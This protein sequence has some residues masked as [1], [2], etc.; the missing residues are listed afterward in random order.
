MAPSLKSRLARPATLAA[1]FL[2]CVSVYTVF[3]S[4]APRQLLNETPTDYVWKYRRVARN[5]LA[6]HGH[7]WKA[8]RGLYTAVPP[9]Y[10]LWV[11]AVYAVAGDDVIREPR[12]IHVSNAITLALCSV[13]VFLIAEQMLG[14]RL[15]GAWAAALWM[16]YPLQLWMVP[17]PLSEVPFTLF[18]YVGVW[19]AL[20]ALPDGRNGWSFGAGLA[21]GVAALMRPIGIAIP[22]VAFASLALTPGRPWR[23]RL[24]SAALVVLGFVVAILPWETYAY[25]ETGKIIPLSGGGGSALMGGLVWI[26]RPEAETAALDR[27][28]DIVSL[29]ERAN[30]VWQ[31]ADRDKGAVIRF[32]AAESLRN[33]LTTAKL[34][35]LKATRAWYG[36]YSMRHEGAV[37]AMQL[38]YLALATVGITLL[39]RA[40]ALPVAPHILPAALMF[41]FYGMAIIFP[42]NVRFLVP[43]LGLMLVYPAITLDHAA[44][45]VGRLIRARRDRSSKGNGDAPKDGGRESNESRE[46][47]A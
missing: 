10:P 14:T 42:P 24:V 3:L 43:T 7:V 23:T 40:R 38:A 46:T 18:L 37:L 11:T 12:P 31:A 6:G 25:R 21:F 27:P 45:R 39:I 36:T 30:N 13:F 33:P 26:I 5:L 19:A 2:V 20:R 47:S 28:P 16:T 9:G 1:V 15:R 34:L 35:A 32:L 29:V 41:A 4:I 22:P 17:L 44:G 8:G